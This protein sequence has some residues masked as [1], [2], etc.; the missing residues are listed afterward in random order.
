MANSVPVTKY[1]ELFSD[2]VI[3]GPI[4]GGYDILFDQ[5]I[6]TDD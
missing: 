4:N 1:V 6:A 5:K 2:Q 3:P